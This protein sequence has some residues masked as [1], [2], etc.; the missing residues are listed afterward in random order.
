MTSTVFV[1]FNKWHEFVISNYLHITIN[2]ANVGDQFN[3]QTSN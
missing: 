1:S 3:V 2:E